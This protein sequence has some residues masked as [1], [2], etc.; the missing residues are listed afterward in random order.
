MIKDER[1]EATF[2]AKQNIK[3]NR[4]PLL[5]LRGTIGRKN[6]KRLFLRGYYTNN[7]YFRYQGSKK[8]IQ[9]S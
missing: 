9:L 7:D 3:Y 8:Y 5:I 2:K 1:S 6:A 4:K